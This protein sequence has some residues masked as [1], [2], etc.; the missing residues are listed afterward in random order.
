PDGAAG[1]DGVR[2]RL[3]TGSGLVATPRGLLV[4]STT[5]PL[6]V[7]DGGNVPLDIVESGSPGGDLLVRAGARS[8]GDAAAGGNR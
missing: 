6:E 7:P 3:W 8:S 4:G 5:L 1:A 2:V